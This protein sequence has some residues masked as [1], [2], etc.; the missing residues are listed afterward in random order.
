VSQLAYTSF[1]LKRT[2]RERRL[3]IFSSASR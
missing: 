3:F 1:E 2:F